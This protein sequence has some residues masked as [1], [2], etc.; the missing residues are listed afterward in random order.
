MV[1]FLN[2]QRLNLPIAPFAGAVIGFVAAALFALMPTEMLEDLVVNSGIAAVIAAAEPPLGITARF[3]LIFLVGG[4]I[5]LF[6]WFSLFLLL[7]SRSLVIQPADELEGGDRAPILRRADAHPDAPARRPLSAARDLG[8]PF[9]EVHAERPLHMGV[10]EDDAEVIEV[11]PLTGPA[12]A[13]PEPVEDGEAAE[14][15]AEQTLPADLD[16]PLAAFDPTSIPD[17]PAD[18]FPAP[19][20]LRMTPRRPVFDPS[21]RF[22]TFDLAPAAPRAPAPAP[23]PFTPSVPPMPRPDPSATIHALLDRLERGVARREG[24]APPASPP[25]PPPHR[26]ESLEET[27]EALR[28]LATRR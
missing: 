16:Q 28:R 8:T 4:G 14:A 19:A 10:Q 26:R 1:A 9:L 3:V 18:W 17:D 15:P 6:A 7:G 22:D 24:E 25:A 5:G 2:R 13:A 23:S 21:E 11:A 20:P 27:L 12:G